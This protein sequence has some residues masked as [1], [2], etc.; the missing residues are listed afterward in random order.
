M[1]GSGAGDMGVGASFFLNLQTA[2]S[3]CYLNL[4]GPKVG[5]IQLP[6]ALLVGSIMVLLLDP[7]GDFSAGTRSSP[8]AR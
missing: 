8:Q 6:G 7:L 3:R 2:Q 4:L 1:A 5:I